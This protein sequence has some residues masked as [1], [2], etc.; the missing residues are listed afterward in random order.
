MLRTLEEQEKQLTELVTALPR[1]TVQ[2]GELIADAQR[3]VNRMLRQPK[4]FLT[5]IGKAAQ[6][7]AGLP[8]GDNQSLLQRHAMLA[9]I[10]TDVFTAV[11]D[12]RTEAGR[13]KALK[14]KLARLRADAKAEISSADSLINRHSSLSVS[15]AKEKL[16]NAR[17][18]CLSTGTLEEQLKA[19]QSAVDLARQA[20]RIIERQVRDEQQRLSSSDNSYGSD[21][22][23][24]SSGG[25]GST[26]W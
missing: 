3:D 22:S 2:L 26:D 19:A 25:G 1:M 18:A 13:I 24:S 12:A 20:K 10:Q 17:T 4:P 15:S 14:D 5:R 7:L 16:R 6:Q 9:Q 23:R 8:A 11:N 21:S